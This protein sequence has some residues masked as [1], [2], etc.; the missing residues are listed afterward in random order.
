VNRAITTVEN[1]VAI[2]HGVQGFRELAK[3]DPAENPEEFARAAG[4]ALAGLG[5]VL[6]FLPPPFSSYGTFLSGAGDFFTNMRRALDPNLRWRHREDWQEA[7]G[8]GATRR[9]P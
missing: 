4:Q 6:E 7:M 8:G 3:Y 9:G 1:G 5:G 2:Y